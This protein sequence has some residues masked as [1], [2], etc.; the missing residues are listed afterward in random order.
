MDGSSFIPRLSQIS[1]LCYKRNVK[2][3]VKISLSILRG[4]WVGGQRRD[5]GGNVNITI[6]ISRAI[7]VPPFGLPVR[8]VVT[9]SFAR[10]RAKGRCEVRV[11]L[12][13]ASPIRQGT[14]A[15]DKD[16]FSGVGIATLCFAFA[17]IVR[18]SLFDVSQVGRLQVTVALQVACPIWDGSGGGSRGSFSGRPGA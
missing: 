16:V 15:I 6:S 7:R 1:F 9:R 4:E 14:S 13:V 5:E 12:Q 11:S 2:E 3:R 17:G 18:G 8:L 10:A